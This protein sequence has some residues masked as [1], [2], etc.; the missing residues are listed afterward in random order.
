MIACVKLESATEIW[1]R[2]VD[3]KGECVTT[4]P[5]ALLKLENTSVRDEWRSHELVTAEK[6]KKTSYFVDLKLWHEQG[7][8]ASLTDR[9]DAQKFPLDGRLTVGL[10]GVVPL[11]N[12]GSLTNANLNYF[13]MQKMFT[14]VRLL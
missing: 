6:L 4:Q 2:A 13:Q 3:V 5:P 9:R 12:W 14:A 10:S 11:F 1:T 7:L 8:E